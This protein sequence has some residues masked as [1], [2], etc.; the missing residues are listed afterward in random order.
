M[1]IGFGLYF[2]LQQSALTA[3]KPYLDWPALLLIT[4]LSFL[5]SGFK[6]E[7]GHLLPGVML[8][9]FGVHIYA[10]TVFYIWS[11]HPGVLILVI[12]VGF[13]IQQV[14]YGSGL[15]NGM[16]YFVL[17]VVMLFQPSLSASFDSFSTIWQF[18]PLLL[19]VI[20]GY[21]LFVRKQS[22]PKKGG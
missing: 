6:E 11:D 4:G 22:G 9:G 8:T 12:A 21:W 15:M 3:I 18:W 14:K 2:F 20:G 16:L 10:S 13:F 19:I 7:R 17:A 5:F 1:L